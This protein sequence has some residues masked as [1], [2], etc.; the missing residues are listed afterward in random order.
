MLQRSARTSAFCLPPRCVGFPE[1]PPHSSR[2]QTSC[3]NHPPPPP[4]SQRHTLTSLRCMRIILPHTLELHMG[5]K[6]EGLRPPPTPLCCEGV[7]NPLIIV[8]PLSSVSCSLGLLDPHPRALQPNTHPSRWCSGVVPP[9]LSLA[10]HPA[11]CGTRA[12]VGL[13]TQTWYSMHSLGPA[14]GCSSVTSL[15]CHATSPPPF[16]LFRCTVSLFRTPLSHMALPPPKLH[17]PKDRHM[18]C[19]ACLSPPSSLLIHVPSPDVPAGRQ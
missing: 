13:P 2:G 16:A 8:C 15:T 7:P 18:H 19:P 11:T 12:R 14:L 1:F 9:S 4:P 6:G 5:G 3:N 10:T 17:R